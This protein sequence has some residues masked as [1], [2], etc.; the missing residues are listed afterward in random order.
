MRRKREWNKKWR[1]FIK[2]REIKENIINITEKEGVEDT[3]TSRNVG[4]RETKLFRVLS[5]ETEKR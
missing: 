2:E 5:R 4:E 3:H 1:C